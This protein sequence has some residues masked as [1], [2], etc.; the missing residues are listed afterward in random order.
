MEDIVKNVD[1]N[2]ESRIQPHKTRVD[3]VGKVVRELNNMSIAFGTAFLAFG[4]VFGSLGYLLSDI[5]RS[6]D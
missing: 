2:L 5:S 6:R 4:L 3:V 1:E